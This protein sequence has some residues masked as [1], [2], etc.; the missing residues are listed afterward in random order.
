MILMLIKTALRIL[1]RRKIISGIMIVSLV[2]G[3]TNVFL[4]SGFVFNEYAIDSFHSNRDYIFRMQSDDP[5]VTGDKMN[6]I[7]FSAPEY[8][9]NNFPEVIDYCR[10][11]KQGYDEI[12]VNDNIYYQNVEV[13]DADPSFFSIFSY[14][15]V[16]GNKTN[17]LSGTNNI[18]LTE[19]TAHKFFGD[20][21]AIGSAIVLKEKGVEKI[22]TVTAVVNQPGESHIK[23][24]LLTSIEG[25]QPQGTNA[26]LLLKKGTDY[27]TFEEKLKVHKAEIPFFWEGKTTNYYLNDLKSVNLTKEVKNKIYISLGIAFIIL[28]IA[29]FNYIN[30]YI[31]MIFD[32]IK[33]LSM[34]RLM[35]GSRISLL[36]K[37]GTEISILIIVSTLLSFAALRI[38]LPIFNQLNG[39]SMQFEDFIHLRFMLV[40]S[41][42]IF[43]IAILSYFIVLIS[44]K[45]TFRLHSNN[46]KGITQNKKL[47]TVSAIQYAASIILLICTITLYR[48]VNF[49][50]H[51]E[52]GIDRNVV[53]FRLPELYAEKKQAMK[54][55]LL[56]S[57]IIDRVS[58]CG[59]SPV[60]EAAMIGL[61]YDDLGEKKEYTALL[62]QGD[63]D[64]L[65][66]LHIEMTEGRE[67][68]QTA[69]G[70]KK[71]CYIN[72]AMVKFF[73][74]KNPIGKLVPGTDLEIAGV[75]KNF[76]WTGLE[77]TIQPAIVS[78]TN[79]GRDLLVKI[80]DGQHADGI[81]L[82]K[83]VWSKITQGYPFEY[84]T[85]GELFN[86]K[87]K[88]YEMLLR[89]IS[90][91]CIISIILSSLG[92]IAL[93]LFSIQ[94]KV[95]E[96]GIRKVN[97]ARVIEI[98]V[99]INRKLV[100]WVLFGFV[101]ACP[102]AWY[103]MHK[104]L[105][106]FAY[107]TDMSWWVFALAG[108]IALVIALLTVS[109]QSWRTATRNP[110]EALRYE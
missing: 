38:I 28:F 47:A 62:F 110:V 101:I 13:Y 22:F 41:A 58:V 42:V 92:L 33:E 79:K 11:E 99:L 89:F 31:N 2:V 39:S 8:I 10:L 50:K 25:K 95:K 18:V 71:M 72:E 19:K 53:E 14:H 57:S 105:Q 88:K 68:K 5:W 56:G 49:I 44:L 97:G 103:A 90:F 20:K 1:L 45:K 106:N 24:D 55:E 29:F 3:F 15:F 70:T 27:R 61:K 59:A 36:K 77:I 34:I 66:T 54:N 74:M 76:H 65:K 84:S 78:I 16:D 96:I 108:V 51:K 17:A 7:T 94:R 12:I 109:W 69:N 4:L 91:F 48:Q 107:K 26:Y 87:H 81:N 32:R 102:I 86:D 100:V 60:M 98:L 63:E 40:I 85:T 80:K 64:Y 6:Y 23:F 75:L 83:S 35:G 21:K 43:L 82:I 93:S 52:I 46:L 9:K 67:F 73:Q 104:W 37:L 30:L